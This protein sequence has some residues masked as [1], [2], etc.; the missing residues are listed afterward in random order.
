[1][2]GND[3]IQELEEMVV[4]HRCKLL[5]MGRRIIPHLTEEDLLQPNDFVALEEHPEF[6]YQEGLIAGLH[7]AI[8]CLRASRLLQKEDL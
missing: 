1:M 2:R 3:F 4:A 7:E 8:A 5:A 6:R